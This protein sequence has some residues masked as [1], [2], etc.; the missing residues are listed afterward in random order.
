[1]KL[2]VHVSLGFNGQCESAFKLY[3][4]ALNGRI[5]YML[6]WGDSPAAAQ[7]SPDWAAK[8]YHATLE[9]GGTSIT[10]GDLP[11]DRFERPAGFQLMIEMD[12]AAAAERA[13][14]ALGAGGTI[15]MP[16]QETFWAKRFGT[17][18]DR[19]GVPWSINCE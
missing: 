17:L 14:E 7:A 4:Q 11:A 15:L 10:G 2:N 6:A 5:A 3:E 16:L 9:V 13:F 19:F 18:V 1:M 8:V 12:D